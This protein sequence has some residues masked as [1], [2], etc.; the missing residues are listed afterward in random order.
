VGHPSG[1]TVP[2]MGVGGLFRSRNYCTFAKVLVY[3][4]NDEKFY[5]D[6][7]KDMGR[8]MMSKGLNKNIKESEI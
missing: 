4:L 2:E 1:H 5:S 8:H 7:T 3:N 6:W